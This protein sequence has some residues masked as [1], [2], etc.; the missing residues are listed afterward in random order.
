MRAGPMRC[1]EGAGAA[2]GL[3]KWRIEGVVGHTLRLAYVPVAVPV[4]PV[5]MIDMPVHDVVLCT[6][7][8]PDHDGVQVWCGVTRRRGAVWRQVAHKMEF[9]GEFCSGDSYIVLHTQTQGGEEQEV[10][11]NIHCW[12]GQD[13]DPAE[14]V[15]LAMPYCWDF[16]ATIRI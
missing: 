6:H 8:S 15:G 12:E 9:G 5:N 14:K 7:I 4:L 11:W 10:S 13:S 16:P 2:P 1:F 3:E